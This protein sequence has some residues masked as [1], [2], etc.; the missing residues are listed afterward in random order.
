MNGSATFYLIAVSFLAGLI[1]GAAYHREVARLIG[2][3]VKALQ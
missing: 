2:T 1:F 3:L